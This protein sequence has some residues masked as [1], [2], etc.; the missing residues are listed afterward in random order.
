MDIGLD[1]SFYAP[2]L[3]ILSDQLVTCCYNAW[4]EHR[5]LDVAYG[6][7]R[8]H[9]HYPDQLVGLDYIASEI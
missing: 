5:A 6:V 9:P 4:R 3:P 7:A 1:R 2:L 8:A